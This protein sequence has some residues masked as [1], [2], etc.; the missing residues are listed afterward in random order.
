MKDCQRFQKKLYEWRL[1]D[2]YIINNH[3]VVTKATP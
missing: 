2:V 3:G 1:K